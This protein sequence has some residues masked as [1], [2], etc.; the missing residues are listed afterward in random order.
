MK[1][2]G[3]IFILLGLLM[4]LCAIGLVAYNLCRQQRAGEAKD[5][6]L[7]QMLPQI[8]EVEEYIVIGPA[9]EDIEQ[10]IPD[11]V[12]NPNME[13]PTKE[14]DGRHYIGML[15]IPDLDLVLP[16]IS[17]WSYP[18]LKIAP[19]RYEGSVYQGN[20]IIAAHNYNTHFG[21]LPQLPAGSRIRFTDMDGNEFIYEV[22][23]T[24]VIDP[25]GID[26]MEAGD[27]DLTLFTCTVGG[28]TRFT[29]R[30]VLVQS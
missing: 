17:E 28:R 23:E 13:M 11:Y 16:I 2:K 29:V 21:R 27:W 4:W 12:L 24:E 15:D 18:A 8:P 25:Y 10:V 9:E 26:E 22:V 7:V 3:L 20:L 5:E 14:I 1:N 19:C 30:C 6:V